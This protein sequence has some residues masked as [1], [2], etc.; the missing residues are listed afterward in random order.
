MLVPYTVNTY[1]TLAF[2][3]AKQERVTFASD[4]V[5]VVAAE[6]VV[7]PARSPVFNF[8]SPDF[9]FPVNGLHP[10]LFSPSEGLGFPQF[11]LPQ[12]VV[13]GMGRHHLRMARQCP[14]GGEVQVVHMRVGNQDQVNRRQL[15]GTERRSHQAFGS[16]G[17]ETSIGAN[18]CE[19]DDVVFAVVIDVA[20]LAHHRLAARANVVGPL[21]GRHEAYAL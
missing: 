14:D 12:E 7:T 8:E 4:D 6:S 9:Q 2:V 3:A 10:R 5:A 11:G 16:N 13:S 18:Y 15:S 1:L 17:A 19:A 20:G 21:H